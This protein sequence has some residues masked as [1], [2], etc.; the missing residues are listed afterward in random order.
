MERALV[1]NLFY[2]LVRVSVKPRGYRVPFLQM[3]FQYHSRFVGVKFSS[4]QQSVRRMSENE[5]TGI[6]CPNF[7]ANNVTVENI[8][9]PK[10]KRRETQ[11]GLVN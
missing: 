4:S 1:E 7:F 2:V 8:I 3:L 9:E 6:K 5:T 11:N 10:K